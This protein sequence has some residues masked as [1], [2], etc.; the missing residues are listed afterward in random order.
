MGLNGI[1]G[2]TLTVAVCHNDLL[3][4]GNVGDSEAFLDTGDE[5]ISLTA[6]HRVETT[7]ENNPQEFQRILSAG[8]H[9]S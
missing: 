1:A 3:T 4:V 8:N 9:P 2:S 7:V 5:L 6:D